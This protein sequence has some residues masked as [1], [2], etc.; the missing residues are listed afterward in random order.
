MVFLLTALK[1]FYVLDPNL[2]PIP[3]PTLEDSDAIEAI[4][5]KSEEDELV[6]RGYILNSLSNRLY[7]LYRNMK[8]P[9]EIW[10][11]LEH[12]YM[13]E[14][15]GMDK[16]LA[17]KYFE[18]SI[19]DDKPIMDQVHELQILVSKLSELEIKVPDSLQVGAILSKLPHSWNGYRKKVMHSTDTF[20]IEEFQTHIQIEAENH[21]RDALFLRGYN[22]NYKGHLIKDCKF[23]NAGIK[24][25]SSSENKT[26]LVEQEINELIAIVID[27]QIGMI[28]EVYMVTANKSSDWW[29]DYSATIHVCNN[30]KQ[31]KTCEECKRLRNILM[32]N[33]VPVKVIGKGTVELKFT[34]GQKLTLL[35]VFHVPEIR[36]NLVSTNLLCKKGVK[37]VRESDKV[38][39]SKNGVFIGK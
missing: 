19:T 30:K 13:N 38:I 1:M 7:D 23:K 11:A 21:A 24:I 36:K 35:N 20:T 12:K 18:F 4:R 26:N 27:M 5:S 25:G 28:I 32:G 37:I 22:V 2:E 10:T 14:K 9:K 33:H 15:K 31:F 39:V 6:C 17:L 29:L 34:L 8:T 3:K 16:F